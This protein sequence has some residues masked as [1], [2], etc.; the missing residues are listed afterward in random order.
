MRTRRFAFFREWVAALPRPI[1]ILDVGGTEDYWVRMGFVDPAEVE[2]T[3]VNLDPPAPRRPNVRTLAGDACAMPEFADAAFDVAFSNSVIEHVGDYARQRSMAS[4]IQR[5]GRR[6]FVQTPS[7]TFPI[8]PHFM[9]PWFQY[10]PLAWKAW[11]LMHLSLTFGGRL[12]NREAAIAT[13]RS[14]E[15][16]GEAEF[17]RL[18]PGARLYREKLAGLTKSFIVYGSRYEGEED[19]ATAPR[20]VSGER[21]A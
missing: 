1:R 16:L 21:A 11:L 9:F 7:R 17:T 15:L 2:L 18:F 20:P 19:P 12:P 3:I 13:A 14:V 8:E 4:E 10:L 5:I 6:Y